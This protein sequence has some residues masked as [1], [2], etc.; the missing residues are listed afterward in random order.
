MAEECIRNLIRRW[1]TAWNRHDAEA[2]TAL[3]HPDAE[4][5]NRFGRYLAGHDEHREQF[6]WL[7][8]GP[9][10]GSRSPAQTIVG[11]RFIRPDVA[12]VHATWG[13]PELDIGGQRLRAEDMV[14][15]YLITRED[16]HWAIAAVDLH[17][18]QSGLGQQVKVV[19]APKFVT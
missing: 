14:V 2:L 18:V 17:N 7:H 6:E 19:G 16:G 5:V 8:S 9:F 3:H 15:S 12:L 11:L 4:T 1:D 13:T 10:R